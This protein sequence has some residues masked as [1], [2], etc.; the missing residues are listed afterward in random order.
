MCR[1][2]FDRSTLS[3]VVLERDNGG[4]YCIA[5]CG[6][7]N[8]SSA[9]AFTAETCR[10]LDCTPPDYWFPIALLLLMLRLLLCRQI[11]GHH[12]LRPVHT[13]SVHI[14]ADL[15]VLQHHLHRCRYR[16]DSPGCRGDDAWIDR[17]HWSADCWTMSVSVS[18]HVRCRT[19]TGE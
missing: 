16:T 12:L 4:V 18:I 9:I 1:G 14:P 13:H 8:K 17:G 15:R 5:E 11:H 3:A 7:F 19:C 10:R 2:A 6:M